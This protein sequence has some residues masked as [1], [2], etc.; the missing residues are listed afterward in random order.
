MDSSRVYQGVTGNLPHDFV[1]NLERVAV[2]GTIP[3]CTIIF[4]LPAEIGLARARKRMDAI[5]S[6]ASPDR[7]ERKSWKRTRRAGKPSWIS[8][9]P[10]RFAAA[11]WTPRASRC[12]RRGGLPDRRAHAA[13]PQ[14]PRQQPGECRPMSSPEDA[15]LDGAR[16]PAETLSL[17][18]HDAALAFLGRA[19]KSGKSHHAILI[20]G[21]EVSARQRSRSACQPCSGASGCP[22]RAGCRRSTRSRFRNLP[23]GRLGGVSQSHPPDAAVRRKGWA[24]QERDHHRR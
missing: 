21:P 13:D 24:L 22:V 4:D 1:A 9:L 20:E 3:D 14:P 12:D 17:F 10:S 23:A 11:S 15:I 6:E 2:N 8:L 19:Y 16:P 5:D 18:G 7:F